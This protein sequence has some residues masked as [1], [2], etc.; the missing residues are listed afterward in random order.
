MGIE[1]YRFKLIFNNPNQEYEVHTTEP[2]QFDGI[3]F[4]TEQEDKR[5]GRDVSFM[6]DNVKLVFYKGVVGGPKPN[7]VI[8]N[9]LTHGFEQLL[10]SWENKGFES[11]VRFVIYNDDIEFTQSECDFYDA[12]TDGYSYIELKLIQNTSKQIIKRREDLE[13]DVFSDEDVDGNYIEPIQ[14][15]R[16]LLQAKPV[17]QISEWQVVNNTNFFQTTSPFLNPWVILSNPFRQVTKH[18]INNTITS[19]LGSDWYVDDDPISSSSQQ[20]IYNFGFIDAQNDLTDIYLK[21]EFTVSYYI[22]NDSDINDNWSFGGSGFNNNYMFL[23]TVQSPTGSDGSNIQ[24]SFSSGDDINNY[25]RFIP[26]SIGEPTYIGE[27]DVSGFSNNPFIGTPK[28]Y[29]YNVSFEYSLND[30]ANGKRLIL[31]LQNRR[32]NTLV[33]YTSGY[34]QITTTSTSIDT[35]ANGCRLIDYIKQNVKSISGLDVFAPRLDVGGEHYQNHVF[36]G[37]LIKLRNDVP[38]TVKFKDIVNNLREFNFGYQILDDKVYFGHFNDFYPN[39]E[40]GVFLSPANSE[41][42]YSS[43]PRLAVNQ[44]DFNYK[45][46]EQDNDEENT[47]DAVHTKTQ[48]NT[49]NKR[50]ENTIKIDLDQ[51]RDPYVIAKTQRE[52]IKKT[53]STEEDNK[54]FWLNT[55]NLAP[56]TTKE[57]T[58]NLRHNINNDGNLELL[59]NN[60]FSWLTLGFDVNTVITIV[61]TSNAG[62][63]T[64]IDMTDNLITLSGSPSVNNFEGTLTNISYPLT[65]VLY[66]NRTNEGFAEI[67]NLL[68]STNFSNLEYTPKRNLKRWYPLLASCSQFIT[69]GSLR[70]R[71]FINNGLLETRK[72][73]ETELTIE[74]ADVP[75]EDLGTPVLG[76][77]LYETTFVCSLEQATNLFD[78]INTIN[79]DNTIAGFI[80]VLDANNMP[81]KG[82]PKKLEYEISTGL[83]MATLEEKYQTNII[84][85]TYN[86]GNIYIN[87]VPYTFNPEGWFEINADHLSIFDNNRLRIIRPKRF[88]LVTVN[89]QSSNSSIELSQKLIDLI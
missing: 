67:N 50:V 43:N 14:T 22:E 74:N 79:D 41:N 39:K 58:Q 73:N 57:I 53:T 38:F 55:I 31:A 6:D 28:R 71:Q 80:R 60:N 45:T 16:I 63:Y 12:V 32:N 70:N 82:Y 64:V 75:N 5:Y 87:E 9:Y 42:I 13:V 11:D 49:D 83:M 24:I 77:N 76:G 20:K 1:K 37:N 18:N 59:N 88:D 26:F 51:V 29:D 78:A 40:I 48:W 56:S 17:T 34:A 86:D 89:G 4:I 46:Y 85:I 15:D 30:L 7:G 81:F 62:S 84:D 3:S 27:E 33:N 61:N 44:V 35:V 8:V 72:D 2:V 47:T 68:N 36:N 52:A 54:A 10:E 69:D 23:R 19:L 25:L 21:L 66:T 65:N